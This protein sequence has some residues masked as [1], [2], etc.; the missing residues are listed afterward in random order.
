MGL[1]QLEAVLLSRGGKYWTPL[2]W[3]G[4][5]DS[6]AGWWAL[7]VTSECISDLKHI[8]NVSTYVAV[9]PSHL[10]VSLLFMK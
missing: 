2:E 3:E 5:T 6:D 4:P 9:P 1:L 8:R 10:M 7:D